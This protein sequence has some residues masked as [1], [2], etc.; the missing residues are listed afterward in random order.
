[1]G[2]AHIRRLRR[3][4]RTAARVAQGRAC[5]AGSHRKDRPRKVQRLQQQLSHVFRVLHPRRFFRRQVAGR[6]AQGRDFLHRPSGVRHQRIHERG[7]S[8]RLAWRARADEVLQLCPRGRKDR[9]S[10]QRGQATAIARDDGCFRRGKFWSYGDILSVP[11]TPSPR[12]RHER[13][14]TD[15]V[16]QL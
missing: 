13:A 11:Q 12:Q 7:A 9:P 4:D 5:R 6:M 10:A 1:M 16:V 2:D 8:D 14:S 3:R 15:D